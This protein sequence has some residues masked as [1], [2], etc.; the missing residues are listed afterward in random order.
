MSVEGGEGECERGKK[1]GVCERERGRREGGRRGHLNLQ[2]LCVFVP[3]IQL[4]VCYKTH[5]CTL[6]KRDI[7]A[8]FIYIW[9]HAV[10]FV[11]AQTDA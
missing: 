4:F 1:G 2:F 10:T 11:C 8:L 9:V 5:S 6:H 7:D 3:Q